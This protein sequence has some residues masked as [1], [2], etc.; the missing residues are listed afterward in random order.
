M[1]KTSP[2]PIPSKILVLIW[3]QQGEDHCGVLGISAAEG[4][5][6]FGATVTLARVPD[7]PSIFSPSGAGSGGSPPQAGVSAAST[8]S[9][10]VLAGSTKGGTPGATSSS[11]AN[12][13]LSYPELPLC[14]PEDLKDFDGILTV[15]PSKSGLVCAAMKAF[16]E[17]TGRIWA[18]GEL[19][20]KCGGAICSAPNQHDGHESAIRSMHTIFLHHG[21]IVVGLPQQ[22]KGLSGTEEVKGGTPYGAST[23]SLVDGSRVPSAIELDGCHFQGRFLAE[24]A[25]RLKGP[26][27]TLA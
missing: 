24:V 1:L 7:I 2:K 15:F 16:F 12:P 20:G 10:A 27:S 4:C 3:S 8:A 5:K 19:A 23:V 17:R 13:M 9:M 11:T 18:K 14:E 22:F 26:F 6:A 25:G 21:M